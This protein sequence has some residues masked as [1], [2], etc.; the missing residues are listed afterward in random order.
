MK[1]G[2]AT[3]FGVKLLTPPSFVALAFRNGFVDLNSDLRILNGIDLSIL[4]INLIIFGAVNPQITMAEIATFRTIGKNCC[5]PA[6]YLR[7]Y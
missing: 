4:F 1:V 3:N 2:M 5:F 6:K 7:K